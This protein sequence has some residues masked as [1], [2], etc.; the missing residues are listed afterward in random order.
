MHAVL[1]EHERDAKRIGDAGRKEDD[2]LVPAARL[3]ER[4]DR[5]DAHPG[6]QGPGA[7]ARVTVH[8]LPFAIRTA[9]QE[10]VASLGAL[11]RERHA[12]RY[13]LVARMREQCGELCPFV[14][15]TLSRVGGE[16][17]RNERN[18]KRDDGNDDEHLDERETA[19]A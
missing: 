12:G 4:L 1:P 14:R 19:R 18:E 11:P 3:V 5:G 6:G 10:L 13:R 2:R 9:L 7:Q 17:H 16:L 15:D 8:R